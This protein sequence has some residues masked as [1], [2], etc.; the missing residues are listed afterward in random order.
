MSQHYVS[1]IVSIE[2]EIGAFFWQCVEYELDYDGF[3]A[4]EYVMKEE[5]QT[6]EEKQVEEE[7]KA[8]VQIE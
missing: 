6:I 8:F 4:S 3:G 5:V 7:K 1:K 2:R